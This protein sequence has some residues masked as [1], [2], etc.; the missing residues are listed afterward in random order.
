MGTVVLLQRYGWNAQSSAVKGTSRACGS[1]LWGQQGKVGHYG[2]HLQHTCPIKMKR[3]SK[4]PR[5][6]KNHHDHRLWLSWRTWATLAL[7]GVK[8]NTCT[9]H[10]LADKSSACPCSSKGWPHTGLHWE[11]QIEEH[12][13]SYLLGSHEAASGVLYQAWGLAVQVDGQT[14]ASPGESHWAGLWAA[15]CSVWGWG[16]WVCRLERTNGP[17]WVLFSAACGWKSEGGTR[18]FL[19]GHSKSMRQ[20]RYQLHQRTLQLDIKKKKPSPWGCSVPGMCTQRHGG[21][22][23]LVQCSTE[24]SLFFEQ[25]L[26]P[27]RLEFPSNVKCSLIGLQ[28]FCVLF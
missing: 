6:N 26:E 17:T 22:S 14:G 4:P 27:R 5:D 10:M 16:S 1:G 3:W 28:Y 24:I 11:E 21:I 19:Q 9:L 25:G 8:H 18:C 2:G 7:V 13:C 12:D 15:A 23:V 20:D